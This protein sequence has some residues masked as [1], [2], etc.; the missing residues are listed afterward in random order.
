[1]AKHALGLESG[2]DAEHHAYLAMVSAGVGGGRFG[3]GMGVSEYL[4]RIKLA[5]YGNCRTLGAAFQVPS[6]SGDSYAVFVRNT[7]SLEC[8]RD[9][10]RCLELPEAGFG[11]VENS[12][13]YAD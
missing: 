1:M 7:K 11:I 6:E 4:E 12:P 9:G 10:P 13:G 5:H 3:V 8:F 2:C